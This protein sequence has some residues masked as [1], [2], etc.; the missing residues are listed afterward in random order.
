MASPLPIRCQPKR[1]TFLG[2]L[3]DMSVSSDITQFAGFPVVYK[4]TASSVLRG[5][6]FHQ[7]LS[8]SPRISV[9]EKS[10]SIL[11][12]HLTHPFYHSLSVTH[13]VYQILHRSLPPILGL[14]RIFSPCRS[15]LI[16]EQPNSSEP[17]LQKKLR[18]TSPES[19]SR[20]E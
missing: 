16:R 6:Y 8:R 11:Y 3:R 5:P 9:V 18:S 1:T 10:R 15:H 17:N 7:Q 13:N 12:S 19:A 4:R 20:R 2:I 14:P